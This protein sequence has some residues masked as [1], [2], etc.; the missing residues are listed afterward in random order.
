MQH[1]VAMI[2]LLAGTVPAD[3]L[4]VAPDMQAHVLVRTLAF[5]RALPLRAGTAVG[6]GVVFG[7]PDQDSM[8]SQYE[9][10]R[11]FQRMNGTKLLG[12]SVVV[13][14][15]AYKSAAEL[16]RWIQEKEIDA[17]YIAPGL[18]GEVGAIRALCSEHKIASMGAGRSLVEGGVAIGVVPN[19]RNKLRILVNLAAARSAGMDLDGKL[20]QLA[21]VLPGDVAAR[22]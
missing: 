22:Q 18:G 19:G 11:A 7:T 20:L 17:L 2:F 16:E 15:H 10:R 5:D 1:Y 4:P 13:S 12:R 9:L 3:E 21:E 14:V 6:L 8:R